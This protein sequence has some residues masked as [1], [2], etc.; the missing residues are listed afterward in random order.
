MQGGESAD[1]DFCLEAR[2][3]RT[4]ADLTGQ[5]ARFER[6][7]AGGVVADAVGAEAGPALRGC[8][9]RTALRDGGPVAVSVGEL[10]GLLLAVLVGVMVGVA[11]GVAVG[12]LVGVAVG[13]LVGDAVGVLLGVAVAV[14]VGVAVGVTVSVFVTVGV[15]VGVNVGVSAGGQ[16]EAGMQTH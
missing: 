14:F 7:G 15:A 11:V 5:V 10:V 2:S 9:T 1:R 13:V 16:P 12:V 4:C 8:A 3:T 6:A